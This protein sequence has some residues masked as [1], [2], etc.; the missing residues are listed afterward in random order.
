MSEENR[1]ARLYELEKTTRDFNSLIETLNLIKEKMI[2][3][4]FAIEK[5]PLSI[6]FVD[7]DS[8][9]PPENQFKFNFD[10]LDNQ[11]FDL[12]EIEQMIIHIKK[13]SEKKEQ[14]EKELGVHF[15]FDD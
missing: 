5:D 3:F 1:A 13:L 2:T 15:A 6:I 8:S 12:G 10:E 14:L 7:H 4:A 11:V 9:V